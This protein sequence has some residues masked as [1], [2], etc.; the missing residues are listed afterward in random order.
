MSGE[1]DAKRRE[2]RKKLLAWKKKKAKND[3][4]MTFNSKAQTKVQ[5]VN[6]VKRALFDSDEEEPVERAKRPIKVD[7]VDIDNYLATLD[8]RESSEP[9]VELIDHEEILVERDPLIE[10]ELLQKLATKSGKTVPKHALSTSPI[11]KQFYKESEFVKSISGEEL[12][13]LRLRDGVVVHGKNVVRPIFTWSQLG[14]PQSINAIV[15]S[16]GFDEP[17]PIQAETLPNAMNGSDLIG[18]AKTGS[19]KT[20]AYILPLFRQI[21]SNEYTMPPSWGGSA[22]A[23]LVMAPTRELALQIFD[24]C[25]PFLNALKMRGCC[26]YGGQPISQQIAELKTK[27]DVLVA[28]PGRLI[29]LL[30]ANGGRLLSLSS[31]SYLVLDEA[32]RMFDMGFEPQVMKVIDVL[33]PDRQTVMFS[34]TF[35]PKMEIL[36]RKVLKKPVEILVG[37]RN[38]VNDQIHQKFHVVDDDKFGLLLKELGQFR[39]TDSTGKVLIFMDRQDGCDWMVEKLGPRGYAS[40][41]LHGGQSQTDRDATTDYFKK[42]LFD[43]L[44]AT[45]VASR[46]LDIPD[47]NLVINYDAPSHM[48]DYVHRIGRTGRAGN[49]GTSVTFLKSDQDKSASDIVRLL[50][51]S[52]QP[53][54][55]ELRKMADSFREKV[56]GGNAKFSSGFSGKGLEKLEQIRAEHRKLEKEIFSDETDQEQKSSTP[57]PVTVPELKVDFSEVDG[58]FVAKLEINDL[59]SEAR[60]S[61]S[62]A[63]NITKVIDATSTSIT[64]KGRFYPPG[65]DAG[66]EPKL[67]LQVEGQSK[68]DLLKAVD[69]LKASIVEGLTQSANGNR[70]KEV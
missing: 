31:L 66:K 41:S 14:M 16:L 58:Q 45:S 27:C 28:T 36:A 52:N 17:T 32:D 18:I 54:P 12:A 25:K 65:K 21:M 13:A 60:W 53:V 68:P 64:S 19:G 39:A 48:E 70:Q 8:H 30:C 49:K 22:P 63:D 24:S 11:Y 67:Y 23:A 20:L 35:P 62:N 33:R 2:R 43:I 55:Q 46:G 51:L 44:I 50:E 5:K 9:K 56:K 1:E 15:D 6:S 47:L 42:G 40:M 29:D 37:T 59:P 4:K 57:A 34:A 7:D 38:V 69:L 26:C 3:S 61:V 10:T